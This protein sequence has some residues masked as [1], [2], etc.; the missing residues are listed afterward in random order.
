MNTRKP[1]RATYTDKE[2]LHEGTR[3]ALSLTR[4]KADAE[5]IAQSAWMKLSRK[6]GQV[7]GKNVFFRTIKNTFIDQVR[8][9]RVVSFSPLENAPEP[10]RS[11]TPGYGLDLDLTLSTLSKSERAAIQLNVLEGYTAIEIGKKLGMP[12]GTVL[13]HMSRARNKLREAFG[14]ELGYRKA[15]TA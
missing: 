8:R 3:F 9:N 12:R 7:D 5:D 2:L 15:Q 11:E 6:Y 10:S 13:S 14:Q 4:N 1:T